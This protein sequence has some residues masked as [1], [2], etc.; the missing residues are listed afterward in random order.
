MKCWQNSFIYF[1]NIYS[2]GQ[3]A[4]YWKSIQNINTAVTATATNGDLH[5]AELLN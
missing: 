4:A 2:P 5:C 3:Y 1:I